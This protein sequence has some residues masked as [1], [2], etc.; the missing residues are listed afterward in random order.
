MTNL[1]DLLPAGGG[2][3]NTDFVAD[4]NISSGAPVI[5]TAAGKA[6]PI[7]ST[8]AAFGSEYEFESGITYYTVFN[9]NTTQ[10]RVAAFY[11]DA[12][13]GDYP[14]AV[15]GSVS[16]SVITWGTPVVIVSSAMSDYLAATYDAN[17]DKHL[18]IFKS[19][20]QGKALMGTVTA[21]TN[22]I[23]FGATETF[24]SSNVSNFDLG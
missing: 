18:V 19:S 16:G 8:A 7:A 24:S 5:L 3:N 15:V 17:L 23:S 2:Q 10:D 6:A 1:A 12:S 4:G 14:T 9:Y 21:A 22:T 11:S 20:S 13:N